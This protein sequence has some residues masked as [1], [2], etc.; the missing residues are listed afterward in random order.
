MASNPAS[1]DRDAVIVRYSGLAR[2]ALAGTAIT[3]CDPGAFTDKG[4]G[5]AAYAGTDGAPEDALRASLGKKKP[6]GTPAAEPIAEPT[7]ETVKDRKGPKR[8]AAASASR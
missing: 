5:A 2:T 7:A 8:A 3:D 1:P 4:F 6:A